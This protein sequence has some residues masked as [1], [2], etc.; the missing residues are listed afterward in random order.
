MA[1]SERIS[2]VYPTR[3]RPEMIVRSLRALLANSEL[4]D[5]IVVVDQS[6]S[7]LTRR[8]LEE[9]ACPLVLHVPSAEKGLSNSRNTGIRA[10]QNPILGFI[11]DDCMPARDWMSSAR[12]AIR[13]APGSAVWIGVD[14]DN[15]EAIEEQA[16]A[17]VPEVF[18]SVTGVHDPWTLGPTGGNSFFRRSTF[19]RVGLFDPDLGQGSDFPGAEDGDMVYRVL[20]HGLEVT[21][22]NRIRVHHVVWRN[23]DQTVGNSYNYGLGVGAMLAKYALAGDY[24]PLLRIF[25]RRWL[26][27]YPAVVYYLITGRMHR[28]RDSLRWAQG[29]VRG[30]VDWRKRQLAAARQGS[31]W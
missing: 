31:A 18:Y 17:R 2:V 8:A 22:S 3:D 5:Q 9:L 21:F 23:A 10:S 14:Y 19:D 7:D 29:I 11:D 4:P 30:Y 26:S 27:K 6:H 1:E 16:L 20:R 12:A 13:R 25:P 28:S 15:Q 24:Y